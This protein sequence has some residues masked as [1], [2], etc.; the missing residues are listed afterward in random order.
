MLGFAFEVFCV[1][2]VLTW[3]LVSLSIAK[4]VWFG[5]WL[6]TCLCSSEEE[7]EEEVVHISPQEEEEGVQ[8][9]DYKKA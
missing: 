4:H 7:E 2:P 8:N 5:M 6:L 3:C 1:L 9:E